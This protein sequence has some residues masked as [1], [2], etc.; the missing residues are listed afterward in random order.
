MNAVFVITVNNQYL[1]DADVSD[2]VEAVDIAPIN[3]EQRRWWTFVSSVMAV[4]A[5]GTITRTITVTLTE[6]FLSQFPT[7]AQ[8]TAALTNRFKSFFNMQLPAT[9][10]EEISYV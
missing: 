2:R 9:V 7:E 6:E 1:K 5:A 4:P 10:T 3:E 8:R